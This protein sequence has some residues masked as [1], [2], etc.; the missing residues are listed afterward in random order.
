MTNIKSTV[1][2]S[3][4][5][6]RKQKTGYCRPSSL[7][8]SSFTVRLMFCRQALMQPIFVPLGASSRV[9]DCI[10]LENKEDIMWRLST[11]K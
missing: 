5:S 1:D 6:S 4:T 2:S 10:L 11:N 3:R 8:R 9:Y 7:N